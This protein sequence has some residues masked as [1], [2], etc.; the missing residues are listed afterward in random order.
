VK[1]G[2]LGTKPTTHDRGAKARHLN[3]MFGLFVPNVE[4]TLFEE[5]AANH[6][7]VV[8]LCGFDGLYLDAMDGSSILRGGDEGWY[9]ADKFVVEI[10]KRLKRPTGMAMRAM[11]HHFWQYRTRSAGGSRHP[12]S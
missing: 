7:A 2:A 12:P 10:Q 9:W 5:I 3:E 11:W 4:T 1:R 8:N 6:A